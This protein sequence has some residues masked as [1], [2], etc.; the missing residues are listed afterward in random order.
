MSLRLRLTLLVTFLVVVGA[1]A[2]FMLSLQSARDGILR[3]LASTS[4]MVAEVSELVQRDIERREDLRQT[5][6]IR[7]YLD[8]IERIRHLAVVVEGAGPDL[9][10][11]FQTVSLEGLD[12]PDWFVFVVA[13]APRLLLGV[14]LP[15]GGILQVWADP[16]DEI[17]ES[18]AEMREVMLFRLL[19]LAV[20][21]LI[22]WYFISR[23]LSPVEE[24][25][26]VLESLEQRDFRRNVSKLSLPELEIIGRRINSLSEMLGVSKAE[27]DRLARKA[28]SI[29]EQERRYLARELHDSLG[30]GVSAIK[31]IAVSIRQR[32]Q[33]Q[34]PVTAESAAGIEAIADRAYGSVRD[35]MRDLRP[36]E[37][38]ELGVGPALQ[39][40]VDDWNEHHEETF[41]RL[42]IESHY[43]DLDELQQINVY[44]IVQEAL[45][46]VTKYA[47]ADFV[48]V[49]LGGEEVVSLVISDDGK[50]FDM[51]ATQSGMGMQNLRERVQALQGELY[52]TS[53]P[54]QGVTIRIDFPR[55]V[56][57]RRRASDR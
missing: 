30:Q 24:I 33:A 48:D 17:E 11:R 42:S 15:E 35:M 40:M 47:Q 26:S 9:D 25:A 53:E 41:C 52:V 39:Q 13:P 23:W 12:V 22:L 38:D 8:R 57:P 36:F 46:N 21:N 51:Q 50:G 54:L 49:T 45:T 43:S 28:L 3:E 37:I 29:Q 34:D 5:D 16:T 31:A 18:W 32:I 27:A 20:F 56:R 2:G 7:E 14:E 1:I 6:N 19:V 44:R 10:T 55:R 4:A